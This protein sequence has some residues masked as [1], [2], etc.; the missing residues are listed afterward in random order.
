MIDAKYALKYTFPHTLVHIVDNSMY[1]GP[2]PVQQ[3]YDPSLFSTIVVT[4]MPM[5]EDNKIVTVTRSDVLNTAYGLN[6]VTNADLEKYGQAIEYPMSLINQNAPVKLLR[7]T[8]EDAT[9]GTVVVYVEWRISAEHEGDLEVRLIQADTTTL[10]ENGINVS[11]YKTPERIAKASF[12]KLSKD[13]DGN[14]GWTRRVLM[15]YVSAGRGAAYNNFAV[16]IN[17]ADYD[18]RKKYNNCIYEFG[19]LDVRKS[20]AIDVEAFTAS[21]INDAT[22][23]SLYG[24]VTTAETVN[25]QMKKRL[26]GSSVMIPFVNEAAIRELF[27]QWQIVFQ[28]RYEYDTLTQIADSKMLEIYAKIYED[29]DINK[30]DPIFGKVV[31]NTR[32]LYDNNYVIE[33]TEIS[34]PYMIINTYDPNIPRLSD[35][36]V[37]IIHDYEP[38]DGEGNDVDYDY[39]PDEEIVEDIYEKHINPFLYDQYDY[40]IKTYLGDDN[41]VKNEI[42]YREFG[43]TNTGVLPGTIYLS[44]ASTNPTFNI[45]T[46]V[47]QYTGAISS[48]SIAKVFDIHPSNNISGFYAFYKEDADGNKKY[49]RHSSP[50]SYYLEMDKDC[51][52]ASQCNATAVV[53]KLQNPE[54]EGI[55]GIQASKRLVP[56]GWVI[57]KVAGGYKYIPATGAAFTKGTSDIIDTI[58]RAR[59]DNADKKTKIED[60]QNYNKS[61]TSYIKEDSGSAVIGPVKGTVNFPFGS[62]IAAGYVNENGIRCFKLFLVTSARI[63]ENQR[64]VVESVKEYPSNLFAALDFTSHYSGSAIYD[65]IAFES[66]RR[67]L[68]DPA[69]VAANQL[70]IVRGLYSDVNQ[71]KKYVENKEGGSFT[72]NDEFNHVNNN[73]TSPTCWP[74]AEAFGTTGVLYVDDTRLDS[75]YFEA[76]GGPN[77]GSYVGWLPIDNGKEDLPI[78]RQ[79]VE[80]TTT[81]I[82]EYI[83][84]RKELIQE[85]HSDGRKFTKRPLLLP[86]YSR[87]N[88]RRVGTQP[89]YINTADTLVGRLY[90]IINLSG[91][92][93]DNENIN[94]YNDL[95][96]DAE[97]IKIYASRDKTISRY[98]ISG[99]AM[100]AYRVVNTSTAVPRNYYIDGYGISTSSDQG[101]LRV[102]GGSTGFFDDDNISSV[103]FK[104]KYSELLV[105]AFRGEIDPR[106]LSP[107]RVPAK[108]LFDA[109][110]N[111]MLGIQKL[112]YVDPTIE[113]AVLA[114]TI[115]TDDEKIEFTSKRYLVKNM[116]FKDIDVKQAMYDLMIERCYQRIPENKRPVG[117]GSGLQLY[118]DSG[119]ADIELIKTMNDNFRTR[120]TNPNASWDI[121]GYT[122]S[123]NGMTYTY[124]KKIV[125][126]LFAHCQRYTI[127]KPYA[128]NYAKIT[129]DEY[130]SFFPN[131]DTT[132][133]DLEELLYSSGG[134]SWVLDINQDLRRRSQRTLYREPTGTSDLIQESNMRTLS[135]LIYLL[136]NEIDNWLFEYSDDGTL[137]SMTE[138]VNN[139][140]S[141]WVGTRVDALEI[142]FERDINTDGGDIVV[143]YVNVTF[144]GLI[145]RVPIIVNVNRRTT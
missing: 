112:P 21:L 6:S 92:N 137:A 114:S 5:G 139:I 50:I 95:L 81:Q 76:T 11:L 78:E 13:P 136:Q 104:L 115:F 134:N 27:R 68:I 126:N 130:T 3:I 49:F 90:D 31:L 16:Y 73:T 51:K 61:G 86:T 57:T 48:I 97:N 37:M 65:I 140:F 127:N 28:T 111:T 83:Y 96:D 33:D 35:E 59:D 72:W 132:D 133:W 88:N 87:E 122:S 75:N 119:L 118:L 103:E 144:R 77:G 43:E 141:G 116:L 98:N 54:G 89:A 22:K 17:Q 34:I 12:S 94:L 121:G 42:L 58:A 125:D 62:I 100:S 113:D 9:F 79:S 46:S 19:T 110:Y 105:K 74:M 82:I 71:S 23:L 20:Q 108:F 56:S 8:P 101:G 64:I 128:N 91:K 30:F 55:D 143:C 70:N 107:T 38:K 138:S 85:P 24:V 32:R 102:T 117:P 93:P 47:N 52:T 66:R 41:I 129:S 39:L 123:A 67:E 135:Q 18:K 45:V 26:E 109:G 36:Y 25:V 124:V 53:A 145:L 63:T 2:L 120:F 1:T 106:I 15:T 69:T 142:K 40:P 84:D 44:G 7:I 80:M 29:M 4:G 14:N 99:T 60:G 10:S 131:I